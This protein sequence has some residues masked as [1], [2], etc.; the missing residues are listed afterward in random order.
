MSFLPSVFELLYLVL[1]EQHIFKIII[2]LRGHHRKGITIYNAS[3]VNL[4]QTYF[5]Y[6]L[7]ANELKCIFEQRRKFK[8]VN[9]LYNPIIFVEK[10]FS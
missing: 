9:N 10:M 8:T 2:S 6:T 5:V 4:K 3:E 7:Y 1:T